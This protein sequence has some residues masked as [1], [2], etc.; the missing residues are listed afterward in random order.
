[1]T[2]QAFTSKSCDGGNAEGFVLNVSLVPALASVHPFLTPLK[3]YMIGV[4]AQHPGRECFIWFA[5]YEQSINV[6]AGVTARRIEE[7][8]SSHKWSLTMPNLMG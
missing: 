4:G 3:P 2:D 5:N 6:K 7:V 8:G 1:M